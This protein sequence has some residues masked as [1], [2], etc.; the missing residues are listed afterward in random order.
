MQW[1]SALSPDPSLERAAVECAAAVRR[2]LGAAPDL[3]VVFVSEQHAEYY[4]ELA[5][6][7]EA[8]LEPRHWIGCSAGGVIGRGREIE[9]SPGVSI[10]AA[11]MPGAEIASFHLPPGLFGATGPSS[12]VLCQ[13]TGA[14]VTDDP[15]F[16]VLADPFSFEAEACIRG[17]DSAFPAAAKA[18]GLASG[19]RQPGANALYVDGGLHAGGAVG[20]ALSGEVAMD[21]VVAQGCRPIG[22]PMFVTRCERNL[23]HGLDGRTP[24]EVLADIYESLD[25]RD[26]ELFQQS[27]FLGMVMRPERQEYGQGDFL[28]RNI[29]GVDPKAGCLAIG[30]VLREHMVVQFHLRD[31]RTS[32]A[33]LESMLTTYR[34][35][36]RGEPRGALMFS[37]LGRGRALY[38]RAD[39]DTDLVREHLGSVPLGGFF[40]NGE[41]GPVQGQTFL[42]GYTTSLALFRRRR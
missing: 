24:Y 17:L 11:T 14:A 33:D 3:A 20:V 4:G 35:E 37:C 5:E 38:G 34:A 21:T 16:V 39:H 18:G 12:D 6:W 9:R 41:I 15:A 28:I 40:C 27:L 7:I 2:E 32:R 10:T 19:G 23:L 25:A 8:G 36:G 31:A 29:V 42:H 1:A 26:R 30:A 13:A 22:S